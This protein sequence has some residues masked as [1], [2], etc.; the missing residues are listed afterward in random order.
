VC[1]YAQIFFHPVEKF[2]FLGFLVVRAGPSL[3]KQ[4]AWVASG[5]CQEIACK[6]LLDNDF[7]ACDR[8]FLELDDPG[9]ATDERRRRR[10]VKRIT[11]FDAICKQCGTE[12]RLLE[13]DYLQARLG[14]PGDW[15]AP[16]Q[17]HLLGHISK[18][19]QASMH[20]EMLRNVLRLIYAHLNPEGV[21]HGNAQKD[22]LYRS[23]LQELCANQCARVP[24]S[25]R[26]LT[27]GQT[28]AKWGRA[29]PAGRTSAEAADQEPRA[30]ARE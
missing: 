2:A 24:V 16:E 12:L 26:L 11:R 29:I 20:A 6:L 28:M 19:T 1:G 23:Y 8:L 18:G 9:R 7:R 13:F 22:G 30:S 4:M 27:V 3:G 15:P 25:V 14:L 5:M 10:G 17:P 21:Y